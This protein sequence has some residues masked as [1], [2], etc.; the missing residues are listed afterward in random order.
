MGVQ[1]IFDTLELRD[2][3]TQA[4]FLSVGET[5]IRWA[6]APTERLGPKQR[7]VGLLVDRAKFDVLLLQAAATAGV[8]IFHPGHVRVRSCEDSGWQMVVVSKGESQVIHAAFLVDATGRSGFLPGK[9]ERV[10]QRTL[11]LC[12]YLQGQGCPQATLVEALRDSWCWGAPVPG[13]LFSTMVFLDPSAL[14]P[15]EPG[16]LEKY[17]RGQ[18]AKAELFADISRLPLVGTVF[19]R[20][21]TTY[22]ATDPIGRRFIKV[23]E[24]SF[25]L[26]PL[27]STGVEKAM[28]SGVIAAIALHTMILWP[29]RKDLCTKFYRDRQEETVSAH[30]QW[31]S[32]FYHDV[33]RYAEFPFWLSRS[34][35]S[36][37]DHREQRLLRA[38][39]REHLF[40]PTTQVRISDRARLVEEPCIIDDDI[41]A[42]PALFH[43][44]L[45]RPVAFV[46]G[47]EI[48]WLLEMVSGCPDLGRLLSF[49][50]TRV[51]M[52]RGRRIAAWLM[53]N[54]I[55]EVVSN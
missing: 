19:G 21:A 17:W 9:R 39:L 40:G 31:S 6:E 37:Y 50:S 12:G 29:D 24:A 3:L 14:P 27:S 43:P 35:L 18:L 54:Q 16:T 28:Q 4:G 34:N 11:A 42:R 41:R 44:S 22:Y 30:A 55:L 53:D 45:D 8:R 33:R 2:R 20:D 1:P 5:L 13:G 38:P 51:S 48:G 15:L 52:Q 10:S 36:G 32:G 46:D 25:S 7:G 49:W 26:D 23:G 47:V